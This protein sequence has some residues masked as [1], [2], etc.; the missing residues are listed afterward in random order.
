MSERTSE[1]KWDAAADGYTRAAAMRAALIPATEKML[2]LAGIA[3]GD[4]VLDVGCGP[5]EQT[6]MAAARVGAT[7][8]VLAT[9]SAAP[10]I[11][12]TER[13]IAV[14]GATN[15]STRLC[16]VQALA[17]DTFDA[18]ICRFVLMLLPDPTAAAAAVCDV[19]RPGGRFAAMVH[20]D[21]EKNPLNKL[22]TDILSRHGGVAIDRD[23][24][25]FFSLAN[26]A[27]LEDVMRNA[28]FVD[29]AVTAVSLIRRLDSASSAVAMARAGYAECIRL[30]VDLPLEGQ[31]AAWAEL[32]QALSEFNGPDGCAIPAEVN[33]VVG[34]KPAR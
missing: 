4:R 23:K 26:H 3:S 10:M 11:A 2:D 7:G 22:A 17:G 13:A 19:L 21:P 16:A 28:G 27:R 32:E 30:V 29:V 33:L 15:I 25:G 9:D 8:H 18:A 20:G 31:N 14:A 34:R 5:G 6:L 12:A 1:A 24:P